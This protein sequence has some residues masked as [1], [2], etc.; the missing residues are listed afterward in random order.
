METGRPTRS[1]RDFRG[2]GGGGGGGEGRSE[3]TAAMTGIIYE[4][5]TE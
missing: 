4:Y 1:S 5:T 3:A 2:D